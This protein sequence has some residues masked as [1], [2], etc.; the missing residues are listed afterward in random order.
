[1]DKQVMKYLG[2]R[3]GELVEIRSREE[4]M[5]TLDAD[6]CLEG[7]PF[8]PEMLQFCGQRLRVYKRAHKTCDTVTK[9]GGRRMKNAVHFENARCDGSGHGGCQAACLLFWKEA[10][11]K[12]ISAKEMAAS[13]IASLPRCEGGLPVKWSFST[14]PDAP[15]DQ[16]RYR[17][18]ATELARATSLL[19]WWDLRQYLEDL[20]SG[21]IGFRKLFR[22]ARFALLR[23]LVNVGI[24]YRFIVAAYNWVQRRRG[25]QSFPFVTGTQQK[26]PT[27]ELGLA[28]GEW[29]RVKSFEEI[30]GTL[31][32]KNLNRG[33]GFDNGEMRPHCGRTYKVRGRVTRI[34]DEPTGKMLVMKNPCIVLDGIYCTGETPQL[35]LF[36]PR[37]ITP[38]WREIWLERVP[39]R[40]SSDH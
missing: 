34:I 27:A 23:K 25:G 24:G 35:R 3:A 13:P 5:A 9:T 28:P 33:L 39:P 7:L 4:I 21:N 40:R 10:W 38:Y 2:L 14:G 11:L 26:T 22:G 15:E 8:M 36:C 20:T 37:A 29:V 17:C 31:D 1:M 16:I 18:Q 30:L 6:G 32:G 12:R 19:Q